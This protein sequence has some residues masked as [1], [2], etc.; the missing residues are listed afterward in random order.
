MKY[1]V[2]VLTYF[3]PK[4][5]P[6]PVGRWNNDYTQANKKVDFSNEDHCGPC[7]QNLLNKNVLNKNLFKEIELF[8]D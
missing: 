2:R 3:K 4:D 1:L 6:K 7:G 5:I 8:K